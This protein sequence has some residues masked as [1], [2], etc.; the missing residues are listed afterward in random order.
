MQGFARRH[1]V[2]AALTWLDAHVRQLDAED[3]LLRQAAGRVLVSPIASTV[4]IPGFDRAT[5]DGY[6]VVADSTEGAS[7]YNRIPLQV[8]GDALPGAPFARTVA[9]GEA[10]RI[11]TGAPMPM[12]SDAVLPA[13]FVEASRGGPSDPPSLDQPDAVVA[14]STVSPGKNV[15]RRGEDIVAGTTVLDA[16][17]LLRPQDLGVMSS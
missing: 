17:R 12:G 11:M 4:D 7:A 15:G 6:A 3:I 13:E 10:V 16:G 8:I 1:T 2:Q 14:M 5:M 9:R